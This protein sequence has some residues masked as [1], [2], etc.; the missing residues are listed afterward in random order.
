MVANLT[1]GKSEFA[2]RYEE[3]DALAVKAQGI[4]DQLLA[5]VDEDTQAFNGVMEA[6]RMPKD[7]AE[8]KTARSEALQSG[9]KLATEVPM[10][11]AR[12]CHAALDLCLLAARSGSDAMITDA[13]VGALVSLAGVKGAACNAR[14]NL[15]SIKDAGYVKRTGA[16]ISRL[17]DESRKIADLVDSEVERVTG[18]S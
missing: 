5:A 9:Y 12:R 6:L 3:L 8:Q 11:T 2:G 4:K 16:E 15:K 18:K 14:I 13:G 17:V 7:T 1:V 10:Q